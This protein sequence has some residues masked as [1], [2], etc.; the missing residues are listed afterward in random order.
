M[1]FRDKLKRRA[2]GWLSR[3]LERERRSAQGAEACLLGAGSSLTPEAEVNNF[4]GGPETITV[5]CNSFV[6]GRLVT[7]GHGGRISIGD[8]C[9]VGHRT[10]IWS[11]DSIKIGNR[12]LIAHDV[13][14][15]DGSGL[16]ERV[17]PL[18]GSDGF[19][20]IR[21]VLDPIELYLETC[22]LPLIDE[23]FLHQRIDRFDHA[24]R[25]G[26]GLHLEVV[27]FQDHADWLRGGFRRI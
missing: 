14:I 24:L 22:E 1:R 10:E 16:P 15:H 8:W 2:F 6:R 27:K 3:E 23:A 26:G 12:V 7:Y 9:Y 20:E 4:S 17:V 13:N 19:P 18:G 25:G 11:M 5:G 21:F